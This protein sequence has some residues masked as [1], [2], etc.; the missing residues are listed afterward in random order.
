MVR[1][2]TLIFVAGVVVIFWAF[3]P[4]ERLFDAFQPMVVALSVIIAAIFVRLNRGMPTLEWKSL[5]RQKRTEL[6]ARIVE[7]SKEYVAI[8]AINGTALI[9]LVTLV[10][11]GKDHTM[12]NLSVPIQKGVAAGVG[13]LFSLCLARMAYVVWRDCDIMELQKYLIDNAAERDDKELEIKAAEQKLLNMKG[14]GL[15]KQ[16]S[17]ETSEL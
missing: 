2:L 6:T 5:E 8:V 14:A 10:V 1:A 9:A 13:A 15:R 16:V 12:A 11:A 7:L 4:L 3:V 17:T